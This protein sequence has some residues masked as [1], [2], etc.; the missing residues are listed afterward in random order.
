VL[1]GNDV[2][3]LTPEL[4]VVLSATAVYLLGAFL[5]G[6]KF[7]GPVGLAAI[8]VA[9]FTL[10]GQARSIDPTT[11]TGPLSAD[12]LGYY[13]RLMALV[14]GGV[15]VLA[16]SRPQNE[17]L[18]SEYV[19]TL[20]MAVSGVMLV[21]SARELVMLFLGLEL[22]S[23]PTYVLLFIARRDGASSESAAKYF[24]LSI[25]SSGLTLYGFSFLYGVGG[26]TDLAGIRQVLEGDTAVAGAPIFALLALVLVFAGLGFKIAAV[27]FHFYAPDVYQGTTN[28]N[29]G[30][31]AVL[32]KIAGIVALVR[33]VAIAMPGVEEQ[34]ARVALIVALVTMTLGNVTALWQNDLRR[35]FAY[36]SIAHAGYMLI[37]LAVDFAAR[38]STGDEQ[39]KVEGLGASLFYVGVYA[40]ATAGT[41][42]GLAYLA[43]GSKQIDTVDDLA[44]VGRSNPAIALCV[45]VF[46]F[47]LAGIPPLAGFWGKLGLFSGAVKVGMAAE[48]VKFS[49]WFLVLAIVGVLNAAVSAAYYLRIIGAMYFR[50]SEAKP[51]PAEGGWGAGL[52]TLACGLIVL[53]VGLSPSSMAGFADTSAKSARQTAP[54]APAAAPSE[55]HHASR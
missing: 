17:S 38:T 54:A 5:P 23:I 6:R 15:L 8:A 9:G 1:T 14:V 33:V 37:G 12:A 36:S 35:M 48:Q 13:I 44:G 4:I 40:A 11:I 2:R 29:A 52:A 25:L 53:G 20:M 39:L 21:G 45:A 42:A 19:G 30:V 34:A 51:E 28:V 3:L 26:T 27:P 10:V 31:L 32:P 43:R 18:T 7:W 49:G 41:F 16:G 50:E 47:S 24:F 55:T 22:I 46:M